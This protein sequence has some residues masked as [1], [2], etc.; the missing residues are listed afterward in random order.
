MKNKLKF[1]LILSL[2]LNLVLGFFLFPA[3]LVRARILFYRAF[4]GIAP[5]EAP[6]LKS[7]VLVQD[8]KPVSILDNKDNRLKKMPSMPV[9]ETHGH[10]GKMFHTSPNEVSK[11]L[12]ELNIKRFINL[13]FTTGDEFKKL[14]Q[15]YNDPRITHF[16]TFNWNHLSKENFGE[17]ILAD[18][19][20]DIENGTKGIKLWKNFGLSLKKNNGE[21]LKLDDPALDPVFLECEKAGLIISIHTADP[22]AFFSPID[23]KNERY[24]ELLRHPEWSF[25]SNEFPSLETVLQERNNLFQKHPKLKFVALH[26]GEYANDLS[27]A[28]KLLL[29]NPNVYLDIAARIDELGRQP[30]KAKAFFAKFSDRILFGVDG[31]PDQGKLEIYSRFLETTDEYFDYYPSR[32]PRKG[33]WKIYGLGLDKS[34]L[35]KIYFKNAESLYKE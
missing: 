12:T 33:F 27:K 7:I 2:F 24:E 18:V 28:E 35:E 4:G 14:K 11:L 20:K 8:Y 16:S 32:K 6:S 5:S 23:E 19:K 13:S 3:N 22:E 31:A 30:Y 29:E 9:I 10:L 15:E 26:F 25:A 21:R 17:L 1:L 34:I